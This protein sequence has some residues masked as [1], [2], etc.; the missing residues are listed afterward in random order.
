MS[1]S[2]AAKCGVTSERAQQLRSYF[3]YT[4]PTEITF[5]PPASEIF[6]PKELDLIACCTEHLCE[7]DSIFGDFGSQAVA[8]ALR[9]LGI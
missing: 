1:D 5:D 7:P 2:L 4:T 9:E 6:S 3:T 8:E